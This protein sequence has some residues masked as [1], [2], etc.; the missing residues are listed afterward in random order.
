MLPEFSG[1]S[2]NTQRERGEERASERSGGAPLAPA[3]IH[4]FI[5]MR[6]KPLEAVINNE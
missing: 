1:A 6:D 4:F 5:A 3:L 2:S